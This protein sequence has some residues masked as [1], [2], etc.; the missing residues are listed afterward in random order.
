MNPHSSPKRLLSI[1]GS[2]T[3][4]GRGVYGVR[5]LIWSGQLPIVRF[6]RKIYLDILDLDRYIESKKANYFLRE[7]DERAMNGKSK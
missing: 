1:K 4:L 6:G 7:A 3:Y 5:E 2:A